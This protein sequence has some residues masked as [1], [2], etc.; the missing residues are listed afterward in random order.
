MA[1]QFRSDPVYVKSLQIAATSGED[2]MYTERP[3][4]SA[5][6]DHVVEANTLLSGIGGS[7]DMTK[8]EPGPQM[9]GQDSAIDPMMVDQRHTGSVPVSEVLLNVEEKLSQ[10]EIFKTK[11]KGLLPNLRDW[12]DSK[13]DEL[14]GDSK[15]A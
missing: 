3:H 9:Q 5:G 4:R 13:A 6:S 14:S 10:R 2:Q 12:K 15:E 11:F 7:S 1:K 8:K